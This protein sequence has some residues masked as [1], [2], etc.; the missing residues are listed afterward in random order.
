MN[1]KLYLI[2]LSILLFISIV[3]ANTTTYSFNVD[4][5]DVLVYDCGSDTN[6]NSPILLQSYNSNTDSTSSSKQVS[7]DYPNPSTNTY[8]TYFL[9]DTYLPQ[10]YKLTTS[11]DMTFSQK[12]NCQ[13]Q[14]LPNSLT[15]NPTAPKVNQEVTIDFIL[16]KVFEFTYLSG[17]TSTFIPPGKESFYEANVIVKLL[18]DGDQVGSSQTI[19]IK[20]KESKQVTFK[21]TPTIE[22]SH[23]ITI[24]TNVDDNQ[25]SLPTVPKEYNQDIIVSTQVTT[26][27]TPQQNQ[28]EQSVNCPSS[29]TCPKDAAEKCPNGHPACSCAN[30]NGNLCNEGY[31]CLGTTLVSEESTVCCSTV[32]IPQLESCSPGA[33]PIPC[34]PDSLSCT[35]VKTCENGYWTACTKLDPL[36]NGQP[37]CEDGTPAGRCSAN[38]PGKICSNGELIVY[39]AC[40]VTPPT[41]TTCQELWDCPSWVIIENTD[42]KFCSGDW[43]DMNHCNTYEYY[44]KNQS[45]I[46]SINYESPYVQ[47]QRTGV[48]DEGTFYGASLSS[49]GSNPPGE[50]QNEN[51]IQ[52]LFDKFMAIPRS[53]SIKVGFEYPI[54]LLILSIVIA[55]FVLYGFTHKPAKIIKQIIPKK[56]K[57]KTNAI[58]M[59]DL[60]LSVIESLKGDER[61][62]VDILVEE[63]GTTIGDLIKKTGLNKTKIDIALQKLERRQVIKT[64]KTYDSPIFFNDW[65]K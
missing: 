58:K 14:L 61:R 40:E 23:K 52:T 57:P 24:Q 6:C 8:A 5:V 56:E 26:A 19:S 44:P 33:L 37:D 48:Y 9:R 39:D 47:F 16:D 34:D 42:T 43:V 4:N 55:S 53:F 21:W 22:G 30:L 45:I 46:L 29:T 25:C 13:S 32:C 54:I 18:V 15:L 3:N 64:R 17:S 10:A 1:K 31:S 11:F 28:S 63:E 2:L 7:V 62:I 59:N 50:A 38:N 49:V 27:Q 65:I 36:C 35:M 51:I 20:N 60:L 12:A 41:N